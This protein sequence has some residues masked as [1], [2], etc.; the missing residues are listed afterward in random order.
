[1]R[2]EITIL[3]SELTSPL[4]TSRSAL[5]MLLAGDAGELTDQQRQ[6]LSQLLSL[7]DYMIKL[8]ASWLDMERLASGHIK[9]ELEPCNLGLVLGEIASNGFKVRRSGAWPMVLAD[10]LRL[11]QLII[12]ITSY[13]TTADIRARRHDEYCVVTFSAPESDKAQ[14][15]AI[16]LALNGNQP[17]AVIGLR[18]ASM[19]AQAHGGSLQLDRHAG[20]GLRLRL[21]LPLAQQM[22]LL[23]V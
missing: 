1:M 11:R 17:T 16:R 13:L 2:S 14:R 12:Q 15:R 8:L 18:I 4:T 23:Q 7:D 6:Y 10:P 22:R 21:H 3:A 19:L 9:L 5:A 20:D